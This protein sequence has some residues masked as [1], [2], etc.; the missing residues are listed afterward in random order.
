[1]E[2]L[3]PSEPENR[4]AMESSMTGN[5]CSYD[6]AIGRFESEYISN[7]L[8]AAHGKVDE[9]AKMSGLARATFYRKLK[10]HGLLSHE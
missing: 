9:A 4:Q 1:M 3:L 10:S 6:E 2:G 8:S 7:A 5:L